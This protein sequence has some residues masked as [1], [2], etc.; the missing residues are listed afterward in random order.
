MILITT[1]QKLAVN[2]QK[3]K[4]RESKHTNMGN[5]QHI[6]KTAKKEERNMGTTKQREN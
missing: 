1:E 2:S 3:T 5:H 6:R 4:I